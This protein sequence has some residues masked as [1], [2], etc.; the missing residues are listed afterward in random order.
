M[1][2]DW[3]WQTIEDPHGPLPP[4]PNDSRRVTDAVFH[5]RRITHAVLAAKNP[6][7]DSFLTTVGGLVQIAQRDGVTAYKAGKSDYDLLVVP[8]VTVSGPGLVGISFLIEDA[9]DLEASINA[10]LNKGLDVTR[11]DDDQ[12]SSA[13]LR[14]PDEL[15]VE[16]YHPKGDDRLTAL[17]TPSDGDLWMFGV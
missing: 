9:D 14:D 7:V 16:F 8:A 11:V 6:S 3:D 12:K 17:P 5:P 1:T 10:A 15:A 13:I 2:A 4:D